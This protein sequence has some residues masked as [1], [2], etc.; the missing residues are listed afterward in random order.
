MYHYHYRQ[1][2]RCQTF[3][4]SHISQYTFKIRPSLHIDL[5]FLLCVLCSLKAFA[6]MDF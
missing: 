6:H 3:E 2:Q 1:K 4:I 5:T